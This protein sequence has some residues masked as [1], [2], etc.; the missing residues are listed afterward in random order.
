MWYGDDAFLIYKLKY[1]NDCMPLFVILLIMMYIVYSLLDRRIQQG[2]KDKA[3][4]LF[5]RTYV[6]NV[7]SKVPVKNAKTFIQSYCLS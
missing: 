4:L 6:T 1:K 3:T 7:C 5:Y 2:C